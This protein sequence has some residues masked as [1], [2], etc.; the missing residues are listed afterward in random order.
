MSENASPMLWSFDDGTESTIENPIHVFSD[1][2]NYEV[3][4]FVSDTNNCLDSVSHNITVYYD[5][6]LYVPNSFTPNIDGKNDLFLPKG[7]RMEKYKSFEFKI[8][9]RWGVLVFRTNKISEGWNG[10]NAISGKYA[11]VI[12]IT[13]ELGEVRK[14]VGEVMLIK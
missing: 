4:L 13:D 5:F 10:E 1:P 6:I 9:D 11:W 3:K 2:G 8:F 12:I 14:K 7:L